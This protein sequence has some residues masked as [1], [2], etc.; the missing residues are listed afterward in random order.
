MVAK[1]QFK[2]PTIASYRDKDQKP[3]LPSLVVRCLTRSRSSGQRTKAHKVSSFIKS[4]L[5]KLQILHWAWSRFQRMLILTS[6]VINLSFFIY[7]LQCGESRLACLGSSVIYI[8]QLYRTVRRHLIYIQLVIL[9]SLTVI[10]VKRTP[11][12]L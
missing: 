1:P 3:L 6:L 7:Y 11:L 10:W 2:I 8:W 9:C 4:G 12:L 5:S